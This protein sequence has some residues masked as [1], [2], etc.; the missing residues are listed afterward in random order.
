[1]HHQTWAPS[2]SCVSA[3]RYH[4]SLCLVSSCVEPCSPQR[5]SE[6]VKGTRAVGSNSCV[7]VVRGWLMGVFPM[8]IPG[9]DS[10]C[11]ARWERP[12]ISLQ[13]LIE[14][15]LGAKPCCGQI[16]IGL[17]LGL[18]DGFKDVTAGRVDGR[19]HGYC[20]ISPAPRN[21]PIPLRPVGV[22]GMGWGQERG[23]SLHHCFCIS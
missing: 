8:P 17:A 18:W 4:T 11:P 1:M 12:R 15:S 6:Q 2:S 19:R 5:K 20:W 16:A 3:D 9:R 13:T 10:H 14:T 23:V 7:L 22:L 21:V